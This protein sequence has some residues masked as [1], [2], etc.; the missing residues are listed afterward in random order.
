MKAAVR[1]AK[2]RMLPLCNII[3]RLWCG[4]LGLAD[5]HAASSDV[6]GHVHKDFPTLAHHHPTTSRRHSH[7]FAFLTTGP[8]F[9]KPGLG[10]LSR[11][12]PAGWLGWIPAANM[13]PTLVCI[14]GLVR[15]LRPLEVAAQILGPVVPDA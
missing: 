1:R 4:G 6:L 2:P 3:Q 15:E 11:R 8:H 13:S 12:K 9:T 14:G 7:R 5:S 10:R